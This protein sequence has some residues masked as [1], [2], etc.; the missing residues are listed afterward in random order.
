MYNHI[1]KRDPD[2]PNFGMSKYFS[3]VYDG[4]S[5][6]EISKRNFYFFQNN[7]MPG[8]V[9]MLK[10]IDG[11]KPEEYV[12]AIKTFENKYR[13]SKNTSKV[14]GSNFIE[15]VKVLEMNHKD[16]QLL[17]LDVLTIKKI[18]MIFGIDP[19]LLGFSDDVGAYATM[20]EIAKH[21]MEALNA[22]QTD[23]ETDINSVRRMFQDKQCQYIIKADGE[24]IENRKE[25]ET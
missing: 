12:Q 20:N 25:I 15:D 14:A 16:L 3:V 1:I 18:G 19:R 23:F 9:L 11:A 4:L 8:V 2:R 5:S 24:S 21:S 6:G 7:A 10:N 13:G 17:E 22:Y